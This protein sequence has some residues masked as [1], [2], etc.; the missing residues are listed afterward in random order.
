MQLVALVAGRRRN[1]RSK[2][3]SRPADHQGMSNFARALRPAV[4]HQATDGHLAY[5][6]PCWERRR[7]QILEPVDQELGRDRSNVAAPAGQEIQRS[8]PR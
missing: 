7:S 2:D 4:T 6:L 8:L 1:E 3:R 5:C